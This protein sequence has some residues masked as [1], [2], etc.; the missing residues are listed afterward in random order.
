MIRNSAAYFPRRTNSSTTR[1]AGT[2]PCANCEAIDPKF[3]VALSTVVSKIRS[4]QRAL[5]P[6]MWRRRPSITFAATGQQPNPMAVRGALHA[7]LE[8]VVAIQ[9]QLRGKR[10]VKDLD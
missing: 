5:P 3:E 8:S 6:S 2:P 10:I 4:P 7:Y 1:G 9:G